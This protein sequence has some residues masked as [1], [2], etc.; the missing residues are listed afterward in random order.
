MTTS[1]LSEGDGIRP[2]YLRIGDKF[3]VRPS[4]NAKKFRVNGIVL[5]ICRENGFK[6]FHSEDHGKIRVPVENHPAGEL[7]FPA[8]KLI[9]IR[10]VV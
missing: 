9:F 4:T 3:S 10:N 7:I 8:D 1:K 2:A 5:K 6:N